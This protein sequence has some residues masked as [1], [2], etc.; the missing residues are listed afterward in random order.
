LTDPR[1]FFVLV[2]LIPDVPLSLTFRFYDTP[3]T[4]G[5]EIFDLQRQPDS[6]RYR[7]ALSLWVVEISLFDD[8]TRKLCAL[9]A[10]ATDGE[11]EATSKNYKVSSRTE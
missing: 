1:S 6:D 11:L 8:E 9:V 7:N 2:T 10:V 5:Y 3:T 4:P